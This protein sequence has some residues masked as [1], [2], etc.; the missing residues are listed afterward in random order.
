MLAGAALSGCSDS[1][2]PAPTP[3]PT[4]TATPTASATA[5]RS[6]LP[7]A[8]VTSTVSATPTATVSPTA[9]PTATA[10]PTPTAT[11][12]R[13][14]AAARSA[15]AFSAG[16]LPAD[17]LDPDIP[18]GDD[19][20]L[21]HLVI[22]MQENRSFDHYFGR[23]PAAGHA[24]VDGLP[25]DA[26]NPDAGGNP[27][28]SYHST[29]YCIPDVEHGWNGTHQEWDEGHNDGFVVA[30]DPGGERSM[31]YLDDSDLPFYY[32]LAKTFAI[33]DRFFCA[34]LGPTYPNRFY[35][36]TGTSDGRIDNALDMYARPSIFDRMSAGGVSW[37]I[38]AGDIPFA[39]LLGKSAHV[40]DDFYTDAAAGTLPQVAYVD[41]SFFFNENDEHPPTN[42][43]RGQQFVASLYAAL[44]ASP[45]WSSSAL[46]LLYD[47]HG[48]FY[49]HVP[50]PPACLP[51]DVPPATGP[52]DVQ[53]AFDRDGFRVPLVVVS[54]YSRPGYVS[55]EVYDHTSVL[56]FVETRF[57][58]P[59]LTAR[60]ANATPITDLFDFSQA[61]L[62]N[63]PD[64]PEAVID[65]V[66]D[67]A[68]QQVIS[69]Q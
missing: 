68:C 22:I 26:S 29:E 63:P 15:C 67:A 12:D 57:N 69:E 44:R 64:L 35:F 16:A 1:N 61:R 33:G 3:T 4:A 7:T 28:F 21:E 41:P 32:G 47:E 11:L 25:P 52:D 2:D 39:F 5:T 30:N 58:L 65:P 40:I 19:I 50:P 48:G 36:L 46:I 10:S 8:T 45:N 60:D 38:Y 59:A 13:R 6:P 31:G 23:L 14:K 66:Q 24:D 53:A 34:L 43:Q 18:R 42:P 62:L 49:D 37:K 27:V 54:P 9:S 56:R 17:T 20:P 55:H 51:D